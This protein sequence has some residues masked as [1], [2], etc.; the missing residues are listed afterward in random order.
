MKFSYFSYAMQDLKSQK[1]KTAFGV[2]G[3]FISILLLTIVGS[4]SDSMSYSYLD[5][6]TSQVGSADIMFSKVLEGDMNFDPY[7]DQDLIENKLAGK[8]DAIDYFFPRIL[9]FSQVSHA[10]ATLEYEI[11]TKQLIFYGINTSLEQD[12]G[13]MGDLWI[14]D[15]EYNP[16]DKVYKGPLADGHCIVTRGTAK[17]FHLQVGDNV[18]M[19]F[20]SNEEILIVDAIVDQDKRFSMIE[21]TLV[22]TE[23]PWAQEFLNQ[24]GKVNYVMASI[25]D[26]ETVYDTRDIDGTTRKLR[27]IA[28]EIQEEIGFEYQ[29]SLPKMMELEMSAQSAMSMTMMFSFITFF[30]MMITGILI[31][32][33]LS[34]SV[35]ERVREFGII[36]VLGG[37]RKFTI[38]MILSSGFLMAITGTLLGTAV[39]A[40]VAPSALEWYFKYYGGMQTPLEFIILP[41]TILQSLLI[42]ILITTSISVLPALKAGKTVIAQAIDPTRKSSGDEWHLKKEG[43]VNSKLMIFGLGIATIGILIFVLLPRILATGDMNLMNL[44]FI[45]LLMAV[46]IGLVFACIGFVPILERLIAQLFKP[47]IKRFYPVYR[48]SLSRY[49]RRNT[50]NVVMFALTFAFIFFISSMLEMRS[51]NSA[52]MFEFQ[53]G[54]DLVLS[55]DGNP[56]N[57]NSVDQRLLGEL[58]MLPG[59]KS[60]AP[61]LHNSLDV[62]K[63]A[64]LI[65]QITEEGADMADISFEDIYG[66][67]PKLEARVGDVGDYQDFY[68]NLLGMNESYVETIDNSLLMWDA[69]SGSSD[70]S[71]D[72]LW[73]QP[74]S[75]ILAKALADG[76]GIT[77]LGGSVRLTMYDPEY[78]EGYQNVSLFTVVGISQGM[79]GVWNMR[80]SQMNLHIGAGVLLNME[81]Y[82]RVMAW[83]DLSDP[84]M[85]VDKI[86]INLIDNSYENLKDIQAYIRDFYGT[87]YKFIIDEAVSKIEYMQES[88]ETSGQL[89]ETILFFSIIVSLFGLIASMY[90]TLLERMF[91]IGIL[92]AMG[93]KPYEVRSL[94]IAEAV[95]IMISSGSLGAIIGWFIAYLMNT[96]VSIITEM[97]ASLAVSISTLLSTFLVSIAISVVGMYIITAKVK[98]WSIID[99]L[100]ST[101]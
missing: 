76:L 43:S 51:E 17:I 10:D 40:L 48:L 7:F 52:V 26:R 19:N 88:D 64:A 2:G 63:A 18:T 101:F 65:F 1:V 41:E 62:A 16:T 9:M 34:T 14:C 70:A 90:S 53:Y 11:I 69:P 66:T 56:M 73:D 77:E 25:K 54:S 4:L 38:K 35:E 98:K 23:L 84:Y 83:G 59:I 47:F 21:N 75:C 5:Q 87:D 68:C 39:G 31:N 85:V 22:I 57:N 93:L 36:R 8:I 3:I 61:I 78:P 67:I 58:Q 96:V 45:G 30:S 6:A 24:P 32:S 60:T 50:G 42:G 82:V 99:I 86:L 95:T 97:P 94:F 12:S 55:N 46:L 28:E 80:S 71:L 100:R 79:P 49:R 72:K 92:R 13:T 15:E 44:L 74:N 27:L 29:V 33:I 20:A 89:M 91:E 37:K 81:D